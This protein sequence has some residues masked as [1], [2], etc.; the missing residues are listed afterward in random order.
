M[1]GTGAKSSFLVAEER[2]HRDDQP[3]DDRRWDAV[4]GQKRH[5]ASN[6]AT[7]R[8]DKTDGWQQREQG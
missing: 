2:R 4:A 5:A 7:R 3:P 6:H 8:Q 1:V